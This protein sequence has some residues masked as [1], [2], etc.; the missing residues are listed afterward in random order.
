M[1]ANFSISC[2]SVDIGGLAY[3]RSS[4]AGTTGHGNQNV[5]LRPITFAKNFAQLGEIDFK[6]SGPVRQC[7][8]I[9]VY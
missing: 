3:A 4:I 6:L 8:L 9:I 5:L 1:C 7:R 2:R